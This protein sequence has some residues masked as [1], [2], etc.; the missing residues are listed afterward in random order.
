MNCQEHK[1]HDEALVTMT[2]IMRLVPDNP[3][4]LPLIWRWMAYN[5]PPKHAYISYREPPICKS[6]N[7]NHNQLKLGHVLHTCTILYCGTL[8]IVS[9][10]SLLFGITSMIITEYYTQEYIN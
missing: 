1:L 5:G 10:K 3:R 4:V 7:A 9:Q 6:I 8:L 2:G